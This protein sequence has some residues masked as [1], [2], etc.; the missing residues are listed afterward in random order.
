[1]SESNPVELVVAAFQDERGADDAMDSLKQAKKD[2]LAK[3]TESA[4]V[5]L[6]ANN[7]LH[8]K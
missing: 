8:I 2:H 5:R 7:N 6:D 4:G 1:M 3:I